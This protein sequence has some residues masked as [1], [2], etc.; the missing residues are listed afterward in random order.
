MSS[1]TDFRQ[2]T[3]RTTIPLLLRLLADEAGNGEIVGQAEV[4]DTGE[5]VP[6]C[7]LR[8]LLQLLVRLGA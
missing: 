5:V 7:E 1:V 6:L 4:I 3:R 8:D 2:R